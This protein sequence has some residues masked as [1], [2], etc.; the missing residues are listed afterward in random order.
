MASCK[1]AARAQAASVRPS[2]APVPSGM[3][4]ARP[5][6]AA[7]AFVS[8]APGA[9]RQQAQE[10]QKSFLDMAVDTVL[11]LF[12]DSQEQ[13]TARCAMIV[14]GE[15]MPSEVLLVTGGSFC[16]WAGSL[17]GTTAADLSCCVGGLLFAVG[18]PALLL[19]PCATV[20]SCSCPLS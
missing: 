3:P 4:R 15:G 2:V 19:L 12:D 13:A 20:R 11:S 18:G 9:A 14:V 1:V 6:V 10:A 16:L 17:Q 8:Q 7:A 5:L